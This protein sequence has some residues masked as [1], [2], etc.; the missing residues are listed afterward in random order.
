[1][2]PNDD[3]FIK[4]DSDEIQD[5]EPSDANGEL[6]DADEAPRMSSRSQALGVLAG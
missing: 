1:M 5:S 2:F 4:S 6:L 3:L